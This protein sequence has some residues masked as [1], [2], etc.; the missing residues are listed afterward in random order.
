MG[1][2]QT[3]SGSIFSLHAQED[4]QCLP[5]DLI[6]MI[7]FVDAYNFK[8]CGMYCNAGFGI[9]LRPTHVQLAHFYTALKSEYNTFVVKEHLA[10]RR[11]AAQKASLK[12][13]AVGE[14]GY[15]AMLR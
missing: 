7:V 15:V 6:T 14:S 9:F 10:E 4:R 13:Q 11:A 5:D 2:L 3:C 1:P 12:A 8:D